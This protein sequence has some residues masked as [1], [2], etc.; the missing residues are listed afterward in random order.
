MDNG[1]NDM[2]QVGKN[3]SKKYASMYEKTHQ[4][5]KKCK[6]VNPLTFCTRS[7]YKYCVNYLFLPLAWPGPWCC[8]G[9]VLIVCLTDVGLI[10]SPV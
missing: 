9:L 7:D 4:Y 6:N 3:T 10:R 1:F 5:R 2:I 8:P